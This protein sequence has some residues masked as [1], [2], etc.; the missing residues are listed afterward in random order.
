[1]ASGIIMT[2][3]A[4]KKLLVINPRNGMMLEANSKDALHGPGR[5]GQRA[6]VF[7]KGA[8]GRPSPTIGVEP[9]FTV[10]RQ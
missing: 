1:M 4:I 9:G 6:Q 3:P 10:A 8:G 7:I 5:L 2:N